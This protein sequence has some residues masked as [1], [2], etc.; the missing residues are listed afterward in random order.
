MASPSA[1]T[2]PRRAPARASRKVSPQGPLSIS[3]GHVGWVEG[4]GV[5]TS[6]VSPP[7]P[8]SISYGHVGWVEGCGE[9]AEA[10]AA[11]CDVHGKAAMNGWLALVDET[12]R[13]SQHDGGGAAMSALVQLGDKEAEQ[14]AAQHQQQGV[15]AEGV[16]GEDGEVA[17]PAAAAAA[18]VAVAVGDVQV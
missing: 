4:K 6:R 7:G 1:A 13:A 10:G 12:M 17:T 11:W 9:A 14:E 15:A 5:S 2:T 8:L 3:Q 18:A 16:R